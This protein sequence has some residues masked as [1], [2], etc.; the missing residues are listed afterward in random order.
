MAFHFKLLSFGL[1]LFLTACEE[2]IFEDDISK[3]DIKI[4]AGTVNSNAKANSLYSEFLNWDSLD[5]EFAYKEPN[6]E[7]SKGPYVFICKQNMPN[8]TIKIGI[9]PVNYSVKDG[10]YLLASVSGIANRYNGSNFTFDA[11]GPSKMFYRQLN[12][13]EG[14]LYVD[15]FVFSQ[16]RTPSPNSFRRWIRGRFVIPR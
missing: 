10:Y 12:A 1:L 6:T 14:E 13:T 3:A 4:S 11:Q 5:F 8:D 7:Y 9:N 16:I 2:H 15:C